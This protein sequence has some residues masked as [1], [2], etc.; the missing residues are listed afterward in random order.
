MRLNTLIRRVER[1]RD[2][3][4][5][6]MREVCEGG[7][8]Q[9]WVVD[10]YKGQL[11]EGLNAEGVLMNGGY[12]SKVHEKARRSRGLPTD[13]VYLD[14]EGDMQRGMKVEYSD[15]GFSVVTG[16][17]KQELIDEV[18]RTGYW[19]A[20]NGHGPYY[21]RVFGLTEENMAELTRVVAPMLAASVRRRLLK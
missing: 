18:M 5:G 9:R 2:E 17:W 3:V 11:R 8:V 14:F 16:D 6:M 10:A 15:S 7:K 19:P 1:L 20:S 4:S 12:Y 13:H 21:G